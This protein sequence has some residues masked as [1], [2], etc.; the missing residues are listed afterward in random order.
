MINYVAIG[1]V[2]FMAVLLVS[3]ASC[4]AYVYYRDRRTAQKEFE[5]R[6]RLQHESVLIAALANL[7]AMLERSRASEEALGKTMVALADV[8]AFIVGLE[9]MCKEQGRM[10]DTLAKAV[11]IIQTSFDG[12]GRV[13]D[14]ND[15]L[16][17]EVVEAD[18]QEVRSLI[19]R[20]IPEDQAEQRVRE[21]RL[22]EGLG[23]AR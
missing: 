7:T 6:E 11:S 8:P 18:K 14:E 16:S 22:Y 1:A 5:R 3:V 2:V 19:R 17:P 21:K 20:G 4:V 13:S 10:T 23:A 15:D 9:Q 12:S